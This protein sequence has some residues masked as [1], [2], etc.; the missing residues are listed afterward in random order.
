MKSRKQVKI[1]EDTPK[2]HSELKHPRKRFFA[3][4]VNQQ[5]PL[6]SSTKMLR[7]RC[8]TRLWMHL[9]TPKLKYNI[10]INIKTGTSQSA[11]RFQALWGLLSAKFKATSNELH[12]EKIQLRCYKDI[13]L[14]SNCF[15]ICSNKSIIKRVVKKAM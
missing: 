9:C 3:K 7:L 10:K 6:T 13:L 5:E 11:E 12:Q 8:L 4:T 2:T 15:K 14:I 1:I